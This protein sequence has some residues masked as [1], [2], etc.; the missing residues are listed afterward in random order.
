M[1]QCICLG[2]HGK[3]MPTAVKQ[4]CCPGLPLDCTPG[5][6]G[7]DWVVAWVYSFPPLAASL[8][9]ELP[10]YTH[11][12]TTTMWVPA[13]VEWHCSKQGSQSPFVS[14]LF[15]FTPLCALHRASVST[16]APWE[17]TA[18]ASDKI[19]QALQIQALLKKVLVHLSKQRKSTI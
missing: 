8:S 16:R 19:N 15:F 4:T 9:R 11:S 12:F 7:D 10:A 1:S 3:S 5:F 14:F 17:F 2:Q 6:S 13:H 18:M